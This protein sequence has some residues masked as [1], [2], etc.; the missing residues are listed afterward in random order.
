VNESFGRRV[1]NHTLSTFFLGSDVPTWRRL[2]RD[3]R[4]AVDSEFLP[5]A[6]L[7]TAASLYNSVMQAREERRFGTAVAT[8]TVPPPVIVLGH[9]RSGLAHLQR[10]LALD[11]QFAFPNLHQVRHP[12]TFLSTEGAHARLTGW[13]LPARHPSN[14]LPVAHALP[15]DDEYAMANLTGASPYV[16]GLFPRRRAHYMATYLTLDSASAPEVAGWKRALGGFAR[17]LTWKCGRRPLVLRSPL[18]TGRLRPLLE[19]FPDARLLHVCRNPYAV[20]RVTCSST[21]A[22]WPYNRLQRAPALDVPT[23]VLER[24]TRLYDAYFRERASLRPGQLHEVR[25]ED[26]IKNPIRTLSASYEALALPGFDRLRPRL[27][28]TVRD[29]PGLDAGVGAAELEPSLRAR[30][31]RAWRRSFETWGYPC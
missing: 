31:G 2:L 25:L 10:L 24:Y 9:W 21:A 22:A 28:E 5:R 1:F 20:F 14:G 19:V 3:N 8:V 18:H 23:Y 13:M 4:P 11:D 27:E 16:G 17:K 6:S 30:V 12:R 15:E 7:I 29:D 26:I